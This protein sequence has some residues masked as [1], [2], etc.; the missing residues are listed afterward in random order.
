MLSVGVPSTLKNWYVLCRITFGEHS[1]A[2]LFIK[3]KMDVQGEQ[4]EVIEDER[5]LLHV[6]GQMHLNERKGK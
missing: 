4:E 3:D 6:L 1:P 5:Q 2:T